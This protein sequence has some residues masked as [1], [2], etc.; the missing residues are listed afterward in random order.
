VAFTSAATNLIQNGASAFLN[1]FARDRQAGTNILVSANATQTGG[2]NGNSSAPAISS[3]GR[4]V[5]YASLA[6]NL[7]AGSFTTGSNNLFLR[8]L[9][10]GTNYAL[11]TAGLVCS[12]M[13]S[14]GHFVAFT[15]GAGSAAGKVYLW[16]SQLARRVVTNTYTA[17]IQAVSVSPNG[18]RMAWFSG[19]SAVV[20]SVWNQASNQVSQIA[21]GYSGSRAG[22][23]FSADS[24]FLTY[25]ASGSTTVRTNQVYRYDFL[26]QSSSLVSHMVGSPTAGNGSSDSP[27]LSP[28]G[29]YVVYRSAAGNVVAGGTVGIPQAILF[30]TATG[31]NTL[32]SPSSWGGVAANNRS[33]APLFSGNGQT[34]VFRSWASD[35]TGGDFNESGDLFAYEFL[36]AVIAPASGLGPTISWPF[37]PGQNYSVEYKNNLLDSTW[38]PAPGTIT[39]NG[40]RA[41]LT[42]STPTSAGRFYRVVSGN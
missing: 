41:S 7:T 9:Q 42:D 13:T 12:A 11:T 23:V 33:L 5:L 17:G 22:L 35:I 26:L 38:L 27:A 34:L 2:G 25:A 10:L 6:N 40:N 39:T 24:R 30:D 19:S 18:S 32:I 31:S 20:L 15:D 14:D 21:N 29:R 16:N 1:V 3:D 28:D 4:Y 8:D 37:L 36:Y